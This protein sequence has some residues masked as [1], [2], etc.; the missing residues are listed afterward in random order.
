MLA[1]YLSNRYI[2]VAEGEAQ[3]GKLKASSLY[4]T[5]DTR[6]CILNGT[7]VDPDG[8]LE[9]IG[10][11][12]ESNN[13]SK[14]GI[15]LIIDSNQFTTKVFD[16]PAQK[17]KQMIQYV[18]REFTDVGRIAD[19]VYGYF[20]LK[21]KKG[22]G[23]IK[24]I[25]AMMAPKAYIQGFRDLFE[26]LG[27][28]IA[29]VECAMGT[30]LRFA[31]SI[32]K[33]EEGA[34][35]V[36]FVDNMA[37]INVLLVNGQYM[38]S[39]R[40]RLFSDPG[41]RGYAGEI[42]QAV[43]NIL[44]FTKAQNIPQQVSQ[45]QIAGLSEA[46]FS[47]YTE[48]IAVVNQEI[49]V[50]QIDESQITVEKKAEGEQSVSG[51]AL[52]I[53]GLLKT[54]SKTNMMTQMT[55]DPEKE[56]KRRKQKKILIPVFLLAAV[57]F[58]VTGVL[59]GRTFGLYRQLQEAQEYNNRA[60]VQKACQ[61]YDA[62]SKEVQ[63]TGLLSGNLSGLK[64]CVLSYPRIDSAT[65]QIVAS[66]ASGLVSAEIS[67]YNSATGVL[68]FNTS[69]A[70]VEQINQFIALLS[71][72]D[73]FAVVDYTGYSQDLEGQWN[74]KVNCVMAGRLEAGEEK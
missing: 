13:L 9:L 66:C 12:W 31:Q 67:S 48:G 42:A 39:S 35:V 15:H 26:Q 45:V 7:V 49:E 27:I 54:D 59:A 57:F 65:E 72:Q 14:K 41:T 69:A 47:A 29:S 28:S 37:L 71:Q 25:F 68:S 36:Q 46:D 11:L 34:E 61:D 40:N 5:V 53:S 24:T 3:T 18:S 6:G 58:A 17:Y 23:G 55:R 4:H 43:S 1:V 44:Q 8:F 73:T 50:K 22:N 30:M 16:A 60:D 70:N 51:F 20:P 2:R 21:D 19:P 64:E 32:A 33:E 10:N 52:A 63:I 62:L 56:E 38:Y 74:V